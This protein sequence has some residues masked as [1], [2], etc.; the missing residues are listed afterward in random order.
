MKVLLHVCCGACLKGLL[1]FFKEKE[2]VLYFYNPNIEPKEEYLKKLD[3]VR[4]VAANFGLKLVEDEYENK[5][6]HEV[7]DEDEEGCEI[8]YRMRLEKA[9]LVAKRM[10]F[11]ALATTLIVKNEK[12]IAL[13]NSVG[14]E[15]TEYLGLD[16]L[17][18]KNS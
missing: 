4:M 18:L 6:W 8:G 7:T 10:E 14:K 11:D 17:D 2:L 12:D 15:V 3:S 16:F 5:L 13:I 9:G 1:D